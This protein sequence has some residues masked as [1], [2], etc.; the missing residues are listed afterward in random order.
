MKNMAKTKLSF[1]IPILMHGGLGPMCLAFS[2]LMQER[3][4]GRD[5]KSGELGE[6]VRAIF[7]QSVLILDQ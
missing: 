1:M 3:L 5:A 2:A 7:S 6:P 4:F